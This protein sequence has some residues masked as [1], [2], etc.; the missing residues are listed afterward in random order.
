MELRGHTLR[1]LCLHGFRTNAVVMRHQM[2]GFR[3]SFGDG[4]ADFVF[5]EGP[6]LAM[7]PT[8]EAI[9]SAFGDEMHY[10]E[11]YADK[12]GGEYP[13]RYSGW[14]HSIAHIQDHIRR[15]GPYDVV[16]GF[17]QGGIMATILTAQYQAQ[18]GPMPFKAVVLVGIADTPRDG[19]PASV[20]LMSHSKT[21]C[22]DTPA[23]IIMS[24]ADPF[25]SSGVSIV[26]LFDKAKR[27]YFLHDEGHKFPSSRRYR[28]MYDEVTRE[29]WRIC[30]E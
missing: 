14:E 10:F 8:D 19:M 4:G 13:E 29:L 6:F 22:L 17:S 28:T 15:T 30:R 7:E 25:F 16:V 2:R 23:I 18:G 9:S 27:R 12:F 5:L 24:E 21:H 20:E 3:E 11:W 26:D 1:V